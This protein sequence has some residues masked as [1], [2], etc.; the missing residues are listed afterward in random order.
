MEISLLTYNIYYNK[1]FSKLQELVAMYRPDIICLQE[2]DV[3]N[4]FLEKKLPQNYSL[5]DC[6]NSFIHKDVMFGNA[7]FYNKTKLDF[8]QST[9]FNL[10][11]STYE[12]LYNLFQ[13]VKQ[14][15]TLLKTIF[16]LK[17]TSIEL[18]IY[19]IHF[20]PKATNRT[21]IKQMNLAFNNTLPDISHPQIFAGDFNYPFRRK[22]FEK[23]FHKYDLLEATSNITH[24]LEH[25]FK[26]IRIPLKLD[27]ILYKNIEFIKTTKITTPGSDHYPILSEFNIQYNNHDTI[28]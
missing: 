16:T 27:Y 9:V 24:T 25:K 17:D 12:T 26:F 5:A 19:N 7:T 1:A 8:K 3:K 10:P 15:R 2:V 4:Q 14:N 23:I 18:D 21:R 22:R 13:G 20:T 6:S 28:L 11:F